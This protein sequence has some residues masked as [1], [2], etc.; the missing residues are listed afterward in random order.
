MRQA[1]TSRLKTVSWVCVYSPNPQKPLKRTHGKCTHGE[2]PSHGSG[3]ARAPASRWQRRGCVHAS[4]THTVR[5]R[6]RRPSS[7]RHG[8]SPYSACSDPRGQLAGETLALSSDPRRRSQVLLGPEYILGVGDVSL[9]A[10][11]PC[12]G[13]GLRAPKN[14]GGPGWTNVPAPRPSARE[15]NPLPQ[16]ARHPRLAWG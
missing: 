10:S 13:E 9:V 11:A 5:D 3:P 14:L 15:R 12:S 2:L 7:R 16:P 8:R 4:N 1:L 6:D